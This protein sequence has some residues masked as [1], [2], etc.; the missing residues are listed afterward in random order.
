MVGALRQCFEPG[1]ASESCIGWPLSSVCFV[2]PC[3]ELWQVAQLKPASPESRAS[4]NSRLPSS[5]ALG[6][7][8]FLSGSGPMS[9][10]STDR[11]GVPVRRSMAVQQSTAEIILFFITLLLFETG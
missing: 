2:K 10:Y 11:T 4:K 1:Y 8:A 3:S 9:G 7:G 6:L 5:T